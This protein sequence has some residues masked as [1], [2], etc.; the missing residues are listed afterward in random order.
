M[1]NVK[2]SVYL[3]SYINTL[4]T[5]K[6]CIVTCKKYIDQEPPYLMRQICVLQWV[7]IKTKNAGAKHQ[8]WG[9]GEIKD[10]AI[11]DT[12]TDYKTKDYLLLASVCFKDRRGK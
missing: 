7:A 1:F 12:N 11:V 10:I 3:H 5:G 4:I 9:G 2:E 6:T 8:L